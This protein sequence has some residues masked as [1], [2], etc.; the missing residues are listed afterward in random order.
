MLEE[1]TPKNSDKI[2]HRLFTCRMDCGE[3]GIG[4][5][6]YHIKKLTKG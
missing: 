2:N 6:M 1:K 4:M 5:S 3:Y